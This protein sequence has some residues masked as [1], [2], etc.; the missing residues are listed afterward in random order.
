[1]VRGIST[2][3]YRAHEPGLA[4]HIE[5]IKLSVLLAL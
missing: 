1:M 5:K 3:E 4:G 2:I